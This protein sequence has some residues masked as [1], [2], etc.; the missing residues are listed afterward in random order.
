VSDNFSDAF[1]KL[2]G[3]EGGYTVDNGGPTMWGV[4]EAVARAWGY[5]GDMRNLPKDTAFII[6]RVKYWN[7]N[8]CDDLDA[9]LAF[10]V[11]DAAYNGGHP[12]QWLQQASGVP[13]DGSFGA[14]TL[15]AIQTTDTERMIMRFDAYRLLYMA[16]CT[17]WPQA[18]RG[19]AR[20]IANNLL[21]GA[22]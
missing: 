22:A 20:R 8:H 13:V 19:W 18:S 21:I 12:V 10:Q 14:Q 7:P 3:N 6:A 4:T 15:K 16:D 5:V 11:L 17:V 2:I 9:R 1:T